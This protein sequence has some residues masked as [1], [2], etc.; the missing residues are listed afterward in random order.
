M[1]NESDELTEKGFRRGVITNFSELKEHVLTKCKETKNLEKRF[2][3]RFEEMIKRMDTLER[4]TND[5]MELKNTT[6]ELRKAYTSFSS[7]IDQVEE[8]I[9]DVEDQLNEIK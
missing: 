2:E 3:K 8:R 6:Q 4:N 1:E 7:Q 9:S 5:L